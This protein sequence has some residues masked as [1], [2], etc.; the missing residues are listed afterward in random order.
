MS[1]ATPFFDLSRPLRLVL[2]TN[3]VMALWHFVDPKLA[4]LSALASSTRAVLLTRAE[5]LDELQRVLA[6]RQFAIPAERQKALHADYVALT[7][8]LPAADEVRQAFALTL[9]RCKDRD[10]QKFVSL[11]WDADADVLVTRDKLLLGLARKPPLRERLKI[12]TPERLQQLL[13]QAA[14]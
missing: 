3:V 11:A 10:D 9:P 4:E 2:D 1:D 5:C 7:Q 13:R 12:L 14:D 8:C 6:Y